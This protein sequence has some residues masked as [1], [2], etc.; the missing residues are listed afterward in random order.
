MSLMLFSCKDACD[1]VVCQN[2]GVCVEGICDCLFESGYEGTNCEKEMRS[3]FYGTW[4][5]STAC[6]Y[7]D[8]PDD[9][10]FFEEA[11]IEIT[12]GAED[13]FTIYINEPGGVIDDRVTAVIDP[14]IVDA[15]GFDAEMTDGEGSVI[16]MTGDL[17]VD[18][19][20][21]HTIVIAE[22][23][24]TYCVSGFWRT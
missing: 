14:N 22:E 20:L 4:F 3:N 7:P 1:D 23:D 10:E 6:D 17:N 2:D 5:G 18:T 9:E 12:A 11:T 15:Y 21:I 16:K 19:L 8:V 13:V 24:T